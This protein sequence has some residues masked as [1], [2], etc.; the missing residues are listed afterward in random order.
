MT[1]LASRELAVSPSL[2]A[3]V[4]PDR[5]VDSAAV[6]AKPLQLSTTLTAPDFSGSTLPANV[7]VSA[8]GHRD[9]TERSAPND[10]DHAS[11]RDHNS[12]SQW[13]GWDDAM[14][15]VA[16]H[17]LSAHQLL[18]ELAEVFPHRSLVQTRT[19][20]VSQRIRS[21][22]ASLDECTR[23]E[24]SGPYSPDLTSIASLGESITWHA[25]LTG[26]NHETGFGR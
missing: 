15:D 11:E 9:F 20:H 2:A 24:A 21:A 14:A 19:S 18:N 5:R 25:L 3:V 16:A 13:N 7:R 6:S 26:S 17:L 8:P 22:L 10:L 12:A 4:I 23:L 1:D